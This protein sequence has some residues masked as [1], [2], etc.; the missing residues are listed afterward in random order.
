M[1]L[2]TVSNSCRQTPKTRRLSLLGPC[3]RC[4]LC[5][6]SSSTVPC[7]CSRVSSRRMPSASSIVLVMIPGVV[8]SHLRQLITEQQLAAPAQS[9]VSV[10]WC[11]CPLHPRRNQCMCPAA[12]GPS[13]FLSTVFCKHVLSA[14]ISARLALVTVGAFYFVCCFRSCF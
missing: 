1:K 4:C 5:L 11:H 12:L 13:R 7:F 8:A 2:W 3:D 14:S 6:A 9:H 10:C